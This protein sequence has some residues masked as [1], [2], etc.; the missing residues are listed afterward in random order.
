VFVAVGT[1]TG[2]GAGGCVATAGGVGEGALGGSVGVGGGLVGRG[3]GVRVG[4][5]VRVAVAVNV[6]VG[7]G[8]DEIGGVGVDVGCVVSP[9]S[10]SASAP[11]EDSAA[12]MK[13]LVTPA[14]TPSRAVRDIRAPHRIGAWIRASRRR[15]HHT[16]TALLTSPETIAWRMIAVR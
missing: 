10:G 12:A 13:A 15:A 5:G 11:A 6:R 16:P 8:A 7:V 4:G 2:G 1:P 9:K 3:V 14:S